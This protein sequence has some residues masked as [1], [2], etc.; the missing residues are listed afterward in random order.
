VCHLQHNG[1]LPAESPE[2]VCHCCQDEQFQ[3]L[4]GWVWPQLHDQQ[5]VSAGQRQ[6]VRIVAL[7]C[8]PA[9]L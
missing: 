8:D 3:M 1:V 7:I 9:R 6:R 2:P 4:S 5:A